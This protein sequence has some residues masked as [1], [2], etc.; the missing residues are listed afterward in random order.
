M[1]GVVSI[2]GGFSAQVGQVFAKGLKLDN[3]NNMART[4]TITTTTTTTTT[5]ATTTTTTTTKTTTATTTTITMLKS[6]CKRAQNGKIM[7][8]WVER[9]Q[10]YKTTTT[11]TATTT[12]KTTTK[13]TTMTTK[14]TTTT[15]MVLILIY[16]RAQNGQIIVKW[17]E[18]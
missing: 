3:Y 8:T 5:T 18:Q 16:I 17:P 7:I 6:I 13:T 10:E 14:A 4:N 1:G 9:I 2:L 15:T 11:T 12:T